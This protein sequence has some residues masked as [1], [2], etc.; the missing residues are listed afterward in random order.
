MYGTGTGAGTG[1]DLWSEFW[2]WIALIFRLESL[3]CPAAAAAV[4]LDLSGRVL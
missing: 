1:E 4:D 3:T 2:D